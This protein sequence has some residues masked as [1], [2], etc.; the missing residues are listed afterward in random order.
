[1]PFDINGT[2]VHPAM[3]VP[4]TM[5]ANLGWHPAVSV[6][7]GLNRDGLPVGLQIQGRRHADDVVLRLARIYEQARPWSRHAPSFEA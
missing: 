6:P 2:P 4:F 7:A 5:L 3:N 1:M